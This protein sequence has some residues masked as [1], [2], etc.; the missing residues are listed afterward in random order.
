VPVCCTSSAQPILLVEKQDT[1]LLARLEAHGGAAIVD[2]GVPGGQHRL[3]H[4][5]ALHQAQRACPDQLQLQDGS[6]ANALHLLQS[7]G[8]SIDDLGERAEALQQQLGG[9]FGVAARDAAEQQQLEQLVVGHGISVATHE[10]L[11]Q[12]MA[13]AG[14]QRSRLNERLLESAIRGCGPEIGAAVF[15]PPAHRPSPYAAS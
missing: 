7:L 13:M 6:I 3:L 14:M 12:A 4:D 5:A 8:C 2:H 15:E 1:E 9:R 11:H 10:A